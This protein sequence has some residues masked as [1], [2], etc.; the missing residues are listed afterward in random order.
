MTSEIYKAERKLRGTQMSVAAKL[1]IHQVT[2]ARRETG[3]LPIDREA[4]LAI[5]SLPKKRKKK[6]EAV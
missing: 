2:L 6:N 3:V 1:G 4:E 5:L